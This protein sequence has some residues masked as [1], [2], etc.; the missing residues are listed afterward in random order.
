M[1]GT[2]RDGESMTEEGAP[3]SFNRVDL[4][5]YTN[6]PDP[7]YV[8]CKTYFE[9]M[10]RPKAADRKDGGPTGIEEVEGPSI[11]V[12]RGEIPSLVARFVQG[13]ERMVSMQNLD[14]WE[15]R[16]AVRDPSRGPNGQ[17]ISIT[18]ESLPRQFEHLPTLTDIRAYKTSDFYATTRLLKTWLEDAEI[19]QLSADNPDDQPLIDQQDQVLARYEALRVQ[20]DFIEGLSY[21]QN[22]WME[23]LDRLS[24]RPA[25][26][27]PNE[28]TPEEKDDFRREAVDLL[29]ALKALSDFKKKNRITTPI[30]LDADGIEDTRRLTTKITDLMIRV[31][32]ISPKLPK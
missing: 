10:I 6:S 30:D 25:M 1:A 2:P 22:Q 17:T 19:L 5:H 18:R 15:W 7:R 12:L 8:I 28:V 9:R 29:E 20:K 13:G 24:A 31:A 32:N 26:M 3:S 14:P 4:D 16:P 11:E 21:L 23:R 27:V